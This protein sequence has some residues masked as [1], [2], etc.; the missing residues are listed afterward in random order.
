[1]RIGLPGV[2]SRVNT[3]EKENFPSPGRGELGQTRH[4]PGF[5][6]VQSGPEIACGFAALAVGVDVGQDAVELD[7]NAKGQVR[8]LPGTAALQ[9][10]RILR[11]TLE[12]P[13][14]GGRI[15][16]PVPHS[17][18]RLGLLAVMLTGGC[19][20][21]SAPEAPAAG[22]GTTPIAITGTEKIAWDQSTADPNQ[23]ARLRYIGYVD[24]VPQLLADAA[25]DGTKPI[26]L[27]PC[28][29]SLPP[30][31]FGQ[32][33][34]Q[35]AAEEIDGQQQRSGLSV[36][37]SLNLVMTKAPAATGQIARAGTTSD[38]IPL[39]VE[40]L[41]TG[42]TAP[43]AVATVPDGRVFIAER[44]GN[45]LVWERGQL[46]SSPALQ[47][48]DAVSAG[49]IGLIDITLHPA[50]QTNGRVFMAYTA[51][52][53]GDGFVNRVVRL[54]DVRSSFGEAAVIL[55]ERIAAAPLRPPRVRVGPDGAVYV[56]FPANDRASAESAASYAGKILRINEDGTT[57]RDNPAATPIIVGSDGVIA[58]FDWQPAT[59]R[60]WLAGHDWQ[61]RDFLKNLPFKGDAN[62][63]FGSFVDP[64]GATFYES[65]VIGGFANNMFI[66]ALAGMHI[67]RVRFSRVDP[68]RVESTERLLDGQFGRISGVAAGSDGALYI[69]TSNSGTALATA[70]DDRLLRLSSSGR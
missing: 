22:S 20:G 56:A 60:L 6:F 28:K 4:D 58:G 11:V 37:L 7:G 42:L 53:H 36:S 8:I 2:P 26:G 30:M 17:A 65:R 47:L 3:G 35:L 69:C 45:I 16:P 38:G 51:R 32:H 25:C 41:A 13:H 5:T 9:V 61:G 68:G 44:S 34:F 46:L 49:E 23:F 57:P 18:L 10:D 55:E 14:L 39:A 63:T 43:S 62:L 67:R 27:I 24:G 54:R 52:D 12:T 21:T 1:L 50:F 15:R 31:S 59:G 33:Q 70:G 64:S 66:G 48:T 40:T 19:A 29:A